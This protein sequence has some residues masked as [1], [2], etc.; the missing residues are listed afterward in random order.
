MRPLP[1]PLTTTGAPAGFF[2]GVVDEVRIWNVAR[3]AAQIAATE[4][5]ELT[6]GTG[7]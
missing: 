5:L 4:D 6:S 2:E 7:P 3:T 1:R